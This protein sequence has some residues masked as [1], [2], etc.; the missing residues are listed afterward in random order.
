MRKK[1]PA[2][3]STSCT[4]P[5]PR[6]GAS[7]LVEFAQHDSGEHMGDRTIT[8][9]CTFDSTQ[10]IADLNQPAVGIEQIRAAELGHGLL[11]DVHAL[12]ELSIGR[13][14]RHHVTARAYQNGLIIERA[15]PEDEV[16]KCSLHDH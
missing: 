16:I 9:R 5:D 15:G 3:A 11:E 7:V 2:T 8:R 12:V 13:G 14:E 4:P 1:P 6:G 10:S